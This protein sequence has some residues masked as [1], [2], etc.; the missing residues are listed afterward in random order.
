MISGKSVCSARSAAAEWGVVYEAEDVRLKRT[1]ALKFLPPDLTRSPDARSRF[2]QEAQAASA[3]DHVNICAIHEIDQTPEGQMFIVMEHL[4][5]ET[6]KKKATRGVTAFMRRIFLVS[7][8]FSR[9]FFTI[10]C[11]DRLFNRSL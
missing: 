6:L 1:V 7:P 8:A 11:I 3:L 10:R 2:V 5:G 4:P 9:H